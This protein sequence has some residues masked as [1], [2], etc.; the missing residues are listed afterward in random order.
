VYFVFLV[1]I[2]QLVM[3]NHTTWNILVTG[4]GRPERI[5]Q[6]P[7]SSAATPVLNGIISSTVQLFFAWRIYI[8]K[9]HPIVHSIAVGIALVA[10]MQLGASATV[11]AKFSLLDRHPETLESLKNTVIVWLAGSL[12][13]DVS[14]AVT[15]VI[16]LARSKRLTPFRKTETL[17]NG[18]IFNAVETG[19]VTTI[20]ALLELVLYLKYPDNFIHVSFEF[21]LGRVFSNVLLATLNGRRRLSGSENDFGASHNTHGS[22]LPMN[23]IPQSNFSSTRIGQASDTKVRIHVHETSTSDSFKNSGL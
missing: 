5:G 21:I 9:K 14:I 13:C 2:L 4:Y 23:S 6:T 7:W 8:I 1:E 15:M 17:I 11:T 3:M 12:A 20:F 22:S 19:T 10:L 18:L 16:L